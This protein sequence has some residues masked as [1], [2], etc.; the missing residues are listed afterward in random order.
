MLWISSDG[1]DRWNFLGLKFSIPGFFW[2]GNVV[3]IFLY[4]F[5]G[6]FGYLKQSEDSW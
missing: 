5:W 4:I 3:T 6:F 2:V 1:D